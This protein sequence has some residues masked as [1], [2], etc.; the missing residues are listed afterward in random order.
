MATLSLSTSFF[1]FSSPICGLNWSSSLINSILRPATVQSMLSKYSDM[2]LTLCSVAYAVDPVKELRKP[3]R[4]GERV[5]ARMAGAARLEARTAPAPALPAMKVR[6][7]IRFGLG[8]V[9]PFSSRY[10][11]TVFRGSCQLS[12]NRAKRWLDPQLFA[13]PRSPQTRSGAFCPAAPAKSRVNPFLTILYVFWGQRETTT[14]LLASGGC[15]P[16]ASPSPSRTDQN[17]IGQAFHGHFLA[18]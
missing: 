7:F 9:P 2:P 6:R 15:A 12:W 14:G 18:P 4:I 16:T 3:S 8:M 10:Y 5:W 17:G 1:A 13:A 11:A